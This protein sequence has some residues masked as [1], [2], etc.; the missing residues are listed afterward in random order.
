MTTRS[1][2]AGVNGVPLVQF[3]RTF[4]LASY[5]FYISLSLSLSLSLS[6]LCCAMNREFHYVQSG[7]IVLAKGPRPN[8]LLSFVVFSNDIFQRQSVPAQ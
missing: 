8:S 1:G 7:M 2:Q 5:R 3:D 4:E 6:F